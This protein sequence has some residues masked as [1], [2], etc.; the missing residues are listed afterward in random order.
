MTKLDYEKNKS[1]VYQFD[2][3]GVAKVVLIYSLLVI[4]FGLL[5][6]SD[7]LTGS[8]LILSDTVQPIINSIVNYCPHEV[9]I[10]V[11][12]LGPGWNNSESNTPQQLEI[13]ELLYNINQY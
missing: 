6:N 13:S 9:K 11:I 2:N 8:L 1:D 12:P 10:P 5:L 7:L 3:K 4:G